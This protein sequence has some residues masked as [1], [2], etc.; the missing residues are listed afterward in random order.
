MDQRARRDEIGKMADAIDVFR[1]NIIDKHAGRADPGRSHRG[2]HRRLLAVRRRRQARRLQL[3][4]PRD[5]L[6]WSGY[7]HAG[8]VLRA[9]RQCGGRTC[10]H[11]RQRRPGLAGRADRAAS[12]PGR[13][14][15]AASLRWPLDPRQRTPHRGRRRGG[16]LHRHHRAEG[17]RGR[18]GCGPRPGHRAQ[19]DAAQRQPAHGGRTGRDA[20]PADDAAA[21]ARR[22]A[23]GR[24]PGDRLLHA[25]RARGRRRL[26][27]RAA[28]RRA[29]Q[30]RHRRRHRPR[31]GKRC[32]D[33]DDAGHRAR[34]AD[35]RR[36]RSRALPV[37]AQHRAVRQR[38]AHGQRQE[39]DAVPARLRWR[40]RSRS[41]ASTSK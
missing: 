36:E 8:H 26:L 24:R 37:G 13:A 1:R 11:R 15:R 23:A 22:A 28:A 38:A 35:Q 30:D 19:R 29:G 3:P 2:H 9:H 34:L 10:R 12:Q 20:A 17:P 6:L 7:R 40:A 27:R 18:V 31:P 32:G 16:H 41:A 33:A 21:H 14:A 4:L 5:V 39:P 25:G